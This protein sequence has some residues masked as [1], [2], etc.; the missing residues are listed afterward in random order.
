MRAPKCTAVYITNVWNR[1]MLGT[2]TKAWRFDNSD[3]ENNANH[4]KHSQTDQLHIN[5][6]NHHPHAN[7]WVMLRTV[8]TITSIHKPISF[9]ST[10]RTITSCQSVS[11]VEN[12]ADHYKHSQTDQFHINT[13][14]H[15]P[16]ANQWVM[17]RTM[18]TTTSI[19]KPI[20]FTSTHRTIILTPITEWRLMAD[21]WS[22]WSCDTLLQQNVCSSESNPSISVSSTSSPLSVSTLYAQFHTPHSRDTLHTPWQMLAYMYCIHYCTTTPQLYSVVN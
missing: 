22:S 10:H 15:H 9:T 5:T 18:P 6:Q 2:K 1:K 11:D 12:S 13:Q 8:P 4:Y 20:G 19:H 14:N 16:H 7:Q 17:L 21:T 3:N